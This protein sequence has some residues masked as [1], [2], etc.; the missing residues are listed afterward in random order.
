M[1]RQLSRPGT[2]DRSAEKVGPN[3]RLTV[4]VDVTNTG[5]RSGKEVVQLYIRDIASS[6]QRSEKE[7]KGFAKIALQP[8]ERKTVL[9]QVG[10]EALAYYDD[11]A[12]QWVAEAGDFEILVGASSQDIR[13]RGQFSLLETERF[14]G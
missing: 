14:M 1:W 5:K 6:L 9:F 4:S 13:A 11:R 3:E 2:R 10:R 12:H 8:E 7:L